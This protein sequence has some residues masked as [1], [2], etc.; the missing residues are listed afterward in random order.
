M[1][2]VQTT[3]FGLAAAALYALAARRRPASGAAVAA[4]GLGGVVVVTVFALWPPPTWWDW[5]SSFSASSLQRAAPGLADP[6]VAD[7]PTA[8]PPIAEGPAWTI[9]WVHGAWEGLDRATAPFAGRPGNGWGVA[10]VILLCGI[11]FS[12]IRLALGLLGVGGLRRRSRPIE[13]PDLRALMNELRRRMGCRRGVDLRESP[14]VACPAVVG[15]LRPVVLLPAGWRGWGEPE[16]RA[17]LAHELAH[18]RRF[19]YPLGL[20]AR[21]GVAL[22]FYHPLVHWLADR[23][24]LQQELAADALAAPLVGGREPYLL[25][26]ARLALRQD[27]RRWTSWPANSLFSRG[28]L[29]RRIQLLRTKDGY[30]EAPASRWGRALIAALLAAAV[31][32][33]TA[34][35]CPAQKAEKPAPA[36]ADRAAESTAEAEPFDLSYI[37]SD[38]MGVVAFRPSSVFGRPGLKMQAAAADKQI[39]DLCKFFGLP[40]AIGLSVGQIAQVYAPFRITTDKTRKEGQSDVRFGVPLVIRSVKDFD[41]AKE[42]KGLV[43][44][45]TEARS[46]GRLLYKLPGEWPLDPGPAKVHLVTSSRTAGRSCLTPRQ[47]CAG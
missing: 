28:T 29:M 31:V 41:W 14:D 21:L 36:G 1:V 7:A 44:G 32:G 12:L 20:L 40:R 13:D 35:H 6:P 45:V 10:A 8:S 37:P 25:A 22:H 24:R 19:D 18:V 27:D 43:P 34:L 4:A 30:S 3:L 15:W 47:V 16:R 26:L 42:L 9:H 2:G 39:A 17:V 33:V 46:G 5:R 11:G 23:L 38:A